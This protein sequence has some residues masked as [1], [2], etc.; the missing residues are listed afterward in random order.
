MSSVST[1]SWKPARRAL[2]V[3]T[4]VVGGGRF[5]PYANCASA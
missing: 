4:S 2:I 5:A 1:Q 3:L